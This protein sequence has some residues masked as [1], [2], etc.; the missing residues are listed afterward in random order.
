MVLIYI[1]LIDFGHSKEKPLNLT[2]LYDQVDLFALYLQNTITSSFKRI[3]F[4]KVARDTGNF[5]LRR[6][7]RIMK[8]L[9]NIDHSLPHW[10]TCQTRGTK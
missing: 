5:G 10:D 1:C 9:E 4:T 3:P 8:K 6:L 7:D 2:A